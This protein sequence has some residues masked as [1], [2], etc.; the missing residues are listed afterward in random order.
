MAM[1]ARKSSS[2]RKKNRRE[3][4]GKTAAVK[5]SPRDL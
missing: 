1:M 4:N 3:K 5:A 2:P